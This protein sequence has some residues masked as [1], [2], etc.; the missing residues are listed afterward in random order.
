MRKPLFLFVLSAAL[1]VVSCSDDS[2]QKVV[3]DTFEAAMDAFHNRRF[4]EYMSSVDY[5]CEMDS[6]QRDILVKTYS[7]YL[8]RMH[9]VNDDLLK[10][11]V[12]DVAFS[13]DTVCD[14]FYEMLFADSTA[15]E[16]CQKMVCIGN[17]WKLRAR[18]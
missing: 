9:Q 8:D 3:T 16:R 10:I 14:V 17:V 7:Q 13:S 18:D 6:I 15:V 1:L 12:V 11:K 2:P 4:D 5:G